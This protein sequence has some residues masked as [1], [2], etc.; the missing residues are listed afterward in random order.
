MPEEKKHKFASLLDSILESRT[1]SI[2]AL[3]RLAG[4]IISFSIAVPA[5]QI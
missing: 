2:K 5:A 1:V 4:K 3:Q